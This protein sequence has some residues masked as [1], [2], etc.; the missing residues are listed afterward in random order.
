MVLDAI[1]RR[2]LAFHHRS[3]RGPQG[4]RVVKSLS[5]HLGQVD[6]LLDVGCGDG[7]NLK[8][9]AATAKASRVAGVDVLV[10]PTATI[11][12]VQ[13]DGRTLPFADGSFEGVT[14]VDVLH[15]CHEPVRVLAEALRVASRVVAIKDHFAFGPVTHKMLY[16]M[17]LVGN[18]KD[19]IFSPGNY[20]HPNEW[21]H[22]IASAGGQLEAIDWPLKTHD[23]PWRL[24]G[25]PELQF[26]AKISPVHSRAR[27]VA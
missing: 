4:E 11:D 10:R 18:A 9:L 21:V 23:L 20:L 27:D 25:W 3:S 5:A 1:K 22:L 12:V 14:L 16:W 17:D 7:V 24:V 26:T 6:S 15:H 2:A 19:S 13:Y 8:K